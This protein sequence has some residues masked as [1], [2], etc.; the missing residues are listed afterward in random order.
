KKGIADWRT[1]AGHPKYAEKPAASKRPTVPRR[2]PTSPP[3][4][5]PARPQPPPPPENP[6]LDDVLR[7]NHG[8][9]RV[10]TYDSTVKPHI[11]E[12]HAPPK[13]TED[14]LDKVLSGNKEDRVDQVL[15]GKTPTTS[16]PASSSSSNSSSSSPELDKV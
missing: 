11:L 14:A 9:G 15:A 3:P 12:E 8:N 16:Q 1:I 7:N 2:E 5:P 6:A 10:G 4:Q 13:K